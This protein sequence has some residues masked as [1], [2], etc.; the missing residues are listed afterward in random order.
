M[1]LNPARSNPMSKP[2]HPENRETQS[3]GRLSKIGMLALLSSLCVRFA[4]DA[5]FCLASRFRLAETLDF[6]RYQ[7]LFFEE[8]FQ[9]VFISVFANFFS[10]LLSVYIVFELSPL[11]IKIV[12]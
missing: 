3:T 9:P 5:T 7:S 12:L 11:D 10:I 8:I 4:V 2:P 6:S 1:W